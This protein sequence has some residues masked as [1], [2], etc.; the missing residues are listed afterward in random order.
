MYKRRN[1]H[2]NEIGSEGLPGI[3]SEIFLTA[4]KVEVKFVSGIFK[5]LHSSSFR[6]ESGSG[7]FF[8][9]P[10]LS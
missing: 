8:S 7:D 3:D 9:I 4:F 10:S 5:S 1:V 2:F 6:A